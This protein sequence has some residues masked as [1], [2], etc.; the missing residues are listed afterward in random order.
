MADVPN[1]N[2]DKILLVDPTAD[3]RTSVNQKC[4]QEAY[5]SMKID[6]GK[7]NEHPELTGPFN[8]RRSVCNRNQLAQDIWTKQV[9]PALDNATNSGKPTLILDYSKASV[10]GL[11]NFL[12]NQL[13]L[14]GYVN[15]PRSWSKDIQ[16]KF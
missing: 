2:A 12:A 11:D 9:E 10:G 3:V 13:T 1:P 6:A 15:E 5:D 8:M 4:V 16:V 14:R 7:L